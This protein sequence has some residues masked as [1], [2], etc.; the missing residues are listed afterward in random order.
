MKIN[1]KTA[2]RLSSSSNKENKTKTMDDNIV[3][4]K[5]FCVYEKPF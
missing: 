2:F 1:L 3:K 5:A 4:I